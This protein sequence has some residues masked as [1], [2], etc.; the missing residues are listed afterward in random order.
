MAFFFLA[1]KCLQGAGELF[2]HV[3]IS[4]F[5]LAEQGLVSS[6]HDAIKNPVCQ[7][8]FHDNNVFC[9]TINCRMIGYLNRSD[10]DDTSAFLKSLENILTR[11]S[12][13]KKKNGR[14]L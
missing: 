13:P 14:M 4:H 9:L 8:C 1:G 6:K 3:F 12:R 5:S 7:F 2:G 10:S 11:G